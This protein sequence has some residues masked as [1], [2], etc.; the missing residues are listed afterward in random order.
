MFLKFKI[1][2]KIISIK[3]ELIKIFHLK[4]MKNMLKKFK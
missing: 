4:I 2:K 3:N 1:N